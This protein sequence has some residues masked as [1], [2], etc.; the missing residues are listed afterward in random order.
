MKALLFPHIPNP[1]MCQIYNRR[2]CAPSIY[3][4]SRGGPTPPLPPHLSLTHS[5]VNHLTAV[6]WSILIEG[7][8]PHRL[9]E[10]HMAVRWPSPSR[11]TVGPSCWRHLAAV[12]EQVR[13]RRRKTK[14]VN[15]STS[16]WSRLTVW[17]KVQLRATSL[18]FMCHTLAVN[19]QL[20]RWIMTTVGN[21]FGW[22]SRIEKFSEKSN[23][24]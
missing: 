16:K 22:C 12:T 5:R 1:Y 23:D 9:R 2:G 7:H 17:Q 4:E 20:W 6:W 24:S 14:N 19:P 15:N 21:V 18:H 3:G 13:W 10:C 11:A 8:F